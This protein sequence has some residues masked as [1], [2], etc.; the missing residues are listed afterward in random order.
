MRNRCVFVLG[1]AVTALLSGCC[2]EDARIADLEAQ[3]KA[4]VLH[5]HEEIAKGNIEVFDEVLTPDYIRHCQAMPPGLQELHGTEQFMGFIRDFVG[6]VD[7]LHETIDLIMAEGDKVAYITTM[8]G[9][10]T[11]PMGGLPASGK[12]FSVVNIIIHR[13]EDGKIAETW[14]SWDNVAMLSQLGYFPPPPAVN[15]SESQ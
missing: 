2:S 1:F 4:V 11:G 15:E 14:V 10:Q 9:T 13:L 7:G 3:N 8:T 6:G 12:D 5:V